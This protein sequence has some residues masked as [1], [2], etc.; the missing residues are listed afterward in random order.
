MS[1]PES[2]VDDLTFAL[3]PDITHIAP[4]NREFLR[5]GQWGHSQRHGVQP[6]KR[7]PWRLGQGWKVSTYDS[8][9]P[10]AARS[11][12]TFW[13]ETGRNGERGS[14]RLWTGYQG[15]VGRALG[16]TGLA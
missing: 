4:P 5:A 8:Q 9:A 1:Q 15:A 10:G 2:I 6:P 13:H 12:P 7:T 14:Y 3:S 11:S 16:T